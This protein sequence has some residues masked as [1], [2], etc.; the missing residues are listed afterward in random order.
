MRVI[1]YAVAGAIPLVGLA[2]LSAAGSDAV[3]WCGAVQV[4]TATTGPSTLVTVGTDGVP[5]SIRVLPQ[6]IN[7]IGRDDDNALYGIAQPV[8]ARA[9]FVRISEL[10]QISV[11]GAARGLGDVFVG[12]AHAGRL[13]LLSGN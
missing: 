2:A 11:L 1:A 3:S 6:R 10:G 8:G 12:T 9:Q 7:A 13:L 4:R 5:V